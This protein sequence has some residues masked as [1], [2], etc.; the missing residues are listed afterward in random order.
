MKI[1]LLSSPLRK[2]QQKLDLSSPQIQTVKEREG[3]GCPQCCELPEPT[4]VGMQDLLPLD[5]ISVL[6]TSLV[7]T[8]LPNSIHTAHRTPF[9]RL[10]IKDGQIFH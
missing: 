4:P 2:R 5:G 6:Q 7:A 9:Q 3:F 1:A 8:A 10:A